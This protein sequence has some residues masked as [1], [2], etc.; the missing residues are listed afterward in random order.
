MGML[1]TYYSKP[2]LQ[3]RYW[4]KC[5]TTVT[6]AIHIFKTDISNSNEM[7]KQFEKKKAFMKT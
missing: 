6:M 3:R 2:S 4:I 1:E 7:A 5:I